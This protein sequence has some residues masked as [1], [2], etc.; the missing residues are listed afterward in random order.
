ML[1]TL[2]ILN[3]DAHTVSTEHISGN[4]S[5]EILENIIRG[6]NNRSQSFTVIHVA[7]NYQIPSSC[8]KHNNSIEELKQ[9]TDKYIY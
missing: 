7:I 2:T 4:T 6:I 8:I 1:V 3:V 9:L 5:F